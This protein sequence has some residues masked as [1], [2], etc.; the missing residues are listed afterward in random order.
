MHRDVARE[1]E[2]HT[3]EQAALDVWRQE[4]NWERPHEALGDRFPG[5]VYRDSQRRYTG[6]PEDL[7]YE[8]MAARKVNKIGWLRWKG[9]LY[10]IGTSL[11]AVS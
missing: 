5:E 3:G 4:F 9:E 10:F 6:T 2:P 11:E 7:E 1:L 8:G